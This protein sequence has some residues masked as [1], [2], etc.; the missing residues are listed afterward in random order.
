[1]I[2]F[3]LVLCLLAVVSMAL[4]RRAMAKSA[5]QADTRRELAA[6]ARH[7]AVSAHGGEPVKKLI[8]DEEELAVLDERI[9]QLESDKRWTEVAS[10]LEERAQLVS[11]GERVETLVRVLGIYRDRFAHAKLARET[12]EAILEIDPEHAEARRVVE[13]KRRR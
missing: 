13:K 9:R 2:Y 5:E 1:M 6:R 8:S 11:G 3:F 4:A 12:A 7:H 10:A